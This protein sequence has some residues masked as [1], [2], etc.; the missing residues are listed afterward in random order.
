MLK[1]RK[2]L[3]QPACSGRVDTHNCSAPLSLSDLKVGIY[4][5]K[6]GFRAGVNKMAHKGGE[7]AV[8]TVIAVSYTHLYQ[9][10]CIIPFI[11]TPRINSDFK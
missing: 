9:D 4:I 1:C 3:T 11:A 7:E 8:E 10:C 6:Y 5:I 2:A